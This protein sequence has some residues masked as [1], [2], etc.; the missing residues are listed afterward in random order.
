MDDR[1]RLLFDQLRSL[2]LPA[3][4]FAV[5]GSGPLIVRG[6]IEPG[7]DLDVISRGPAWTMAAAVGEVIHLPEFGVAIASL[8]DGAI[9]I[10]TE[11]AIGD[12]DID[13][14]IDTA[15]VIDSIPFV[16]LEH[17]AAYKRIAGRPKDRSHLEQLARYQARTPAGSLPGPPV[18]EERCPL[19]NA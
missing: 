3:G 9:T 1:S 7:N 12:F 11:W 13:E 15:E 18:E 8:S 19:N 5:F 4:D 6:I 10:G 17:V 16:R 14:L 2:D